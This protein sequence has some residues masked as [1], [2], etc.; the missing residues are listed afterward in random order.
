MEF[1]RL[2][3]LDLSG[4]RVLIRA[5]LNVPLDHGRITDDTRIQASLPAIQHAVSAG[6]SV[7]LMSH[8]GRPTEGSFDPALSLAPVAQR[9]AELL[10]APAFAHQRSTS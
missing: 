5:D 7:L 3:E 8:L 2:S 1:L 10:K 4:K 9:L 6:A